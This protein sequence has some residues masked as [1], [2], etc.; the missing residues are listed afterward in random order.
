MKK[1]SS[2]LLFITLFS[3]FS[4]S[5]MEL[6]L[7]KEQILQDIE[8]NKIIGANPQQKLLSYQTRLKNRQT[9]STNSP[10]GPLALGLGCT[11]LGF[12]QPTALTNFFGQNGF[13]AIT[14]AAAAVSFGA[15]LNNYI[16]K[17]NQQE[18][19]LVD[20]TLSMIN[21][22]KHFINAD[23]KLLLKLAK[24]E[25][26]IELNQ[27]AKS[28]ETLQELKNLRNLLT[29]ELEQGKNRLS[30]IYG[31]LGAIGLGVGFG[32]AGY[33]SQTL[34]EKYLSTI[35]T[36]VCIA[37][38][39]RGF[40]NATFGWDNLHEKKLELVKSAIAHFKKQ[41]QPEE[42]EKEIEEIIEEMEVLE[43]NVEMP[44][45]QPEPE[46]KT[47]RNVR[48]EGAVAQKVKN[49]EVKTKTSLRFP[50]AL[51]KEATSSKC[52]RCIKTYYCSRECQKSH[53]SLHKKT[54][55]PYKKS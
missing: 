12:Y 14:F 26:A 54:C 13:K 46:Q 15:A 34:S 21:T 18:L 40:Y 35:G 55:N 29:Q 32:V 17:N 36:T 48:A 22:N 53:W 50:C 10:V 27:K 51:C 9:H 3:A 25:K 38:G 6:L 41:H 19:E 11:A 23:Y 44:E 7:Q 5:S 28:D 47:T 4:M 31:S 43:V 1:I 37:Q 45:K 33:F 24:A 49:P 42:Q 30:R 20:E 16:P 8:N 52:G 39:A 2:L